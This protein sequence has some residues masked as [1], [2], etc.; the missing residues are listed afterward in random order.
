MMIGKKNP[1]KRELSI[2]INTLENEN[3]V[4]KET[5]KD[6]LYKT[7]MEKLG[8]PQ[9]IERLKKENKHLRKRIK[10]LK[11]VISEGEYANKRNYR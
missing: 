10:A 6:E 11:E 3:K 5:I 1:T 9:T 4:L 2:R 8:E 7:F